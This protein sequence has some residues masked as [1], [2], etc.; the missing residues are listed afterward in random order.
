[1]FTTER[2]ALLALHQNNRSY[3]KLAARTQLFWS[4]SIPFISLS[5]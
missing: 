2:Q 5:N 1:M 4:Y 3:V